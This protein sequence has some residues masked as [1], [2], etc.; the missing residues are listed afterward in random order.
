MIQL[1]SALDFKIFH[2]PLVP[3]A[4]SVDLA[5]FLLMVGLLTVATLGLRACAGRQRLRRGV[6][7]VSTAAFVFGLHPCACMVRDLLKGV[8]LVN[9]DNLRVFQLTMLIVPVAAFAMAWGRVFC[10][11]VCPIGFIQEMAARLTGPMRRSPHP[12]RMRRIRMALAA[13]LLLGTTLVY[14]LWRPANYVVLQGLGAGF[15]IVLAILIMLS[16]ADDRWERRLRVVRY[17]S[18]AFFA[19]GTLLGIYLHAAFCVLFVNDLDTATIMLFVGVTAASLVLS[20]AWCRFLCPEGALLG[21]LT[22]LSGWKIRLDAARCSSCDTC[23]KVCPVEAIELGK[24]DERSCL[25]CCRCVD[26][27][28]TQA[29]AMAGAGAGVREDSLLSLPVVEGDVRCENKEPRGF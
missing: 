7:I 11:W 26:Q 9:F 5:P 25:Y 16:V 15:L 12:L 19:A 10:G 13:A 6:Q 23:R 17:L 14:T 3:V 21:L 1:L 18:L 2:A 8:T 29:L 24:V 22:R 28:P 20:Q 27:C 4:G